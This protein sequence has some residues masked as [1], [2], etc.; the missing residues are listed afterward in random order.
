M[1]IAKLQMGL[2][3]AKKL[4][5]EQPLLVRRSRHTK[6]FFPT[7]FKSGSLL[8]LQIFFLQILG[9]SIAFLGKILVVSSLIKTEKKHFLVLW[10]TSDANI[11]IRYDFVDSEKL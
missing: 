11:A 1:E 10:M 2:S 4:V 7:K 6:C 5:P 9:K 8:V 3:L